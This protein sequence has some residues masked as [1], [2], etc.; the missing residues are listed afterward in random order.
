MQGTNR[1]NL[2]VEIDKNINIIF[3]YIVN[4]IIIEDTFELERS[5]IR[6]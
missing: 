6:L 5:F 4:S 3:K 2:L 1:R